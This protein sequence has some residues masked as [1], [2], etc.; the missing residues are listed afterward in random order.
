MTA[1]DS[2]RGLGEITDAS[3]RVWPFHCV[4]ITNGSRAV[5]VDPLVSFLP[6]TKLGRWEACRVETRPG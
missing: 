5:P 6:V 4:E 2:A 1:F 3:R